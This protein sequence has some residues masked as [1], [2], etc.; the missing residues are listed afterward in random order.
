PVGSWIALEWLERSPHADFSAELGRG[1]ALLHRT[2]A[3]RWGWDRDGYIGRLPQSNRS[4]ARWWE[5]WWEE[6]LL[7]QI[8]LAG[9]RF[10]TS[11][12]LEDLPVALEEI[13][14]PA[15]PEGPCL[16]HGDLWSG[17]VMS[18]TA[19]PAIFDP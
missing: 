3:T 17:N 11:S 5:F 19:G 6:R 4:H 14:A 13:L 1:L 2:R 9:G 18:S 7:P 12:W 16:L 10:E 8:R 15:E